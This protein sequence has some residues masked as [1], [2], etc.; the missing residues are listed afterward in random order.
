I[1][2]LPELMQSGVYGFKIEGRG[3]NEEYQAST[4]KL[5]RELIDLLNGGDKQLFDE[6][7]D[8]A[9]NNF[10][11][12][13]KTLPLNNLKELCCDQERCYYSSHFHAPYK[14]ELS[15][16]SWTKLQCKLLV[17]Q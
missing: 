6:K 13:P 10:V 15:W 1:C 12:L 11:P 2:K 17:V 7:V 8:S 5:Y 16:Q 4:T 9:K 14:K 3:I